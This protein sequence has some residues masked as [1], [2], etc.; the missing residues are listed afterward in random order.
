M[1]TYEVRQDRS[2]HGKSGDTKSFNKRTPRSPDGIPRCCIS[3]ISSFL[4]DY[5]FY[6][7]KQLGRL[8][9]SAGASS[10][11]SRIF[12]ISS[13][14]TFCRLG[15]LPKNIY[16]SSNR[17]LVCE[18]TLDWNCYGT[19]LS[20]GFHDA[21]VTLL[22]YMASASKRAAAAS[23]RRAKP[24]LDYTLVPLPIS[25]NMNCMGI[26]ACGDGIPHF[27]VLLLCWC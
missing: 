17:L 21:T 24:H 13:P 6:L 14:K 9:K 12:R 11:V 5:V 23:E 4:A 26:K 15:L 1:T 10:R 22:I 3:H 7:R 19:L 8:P 27:L 2:I 18:S 20:V 16:L 25:C